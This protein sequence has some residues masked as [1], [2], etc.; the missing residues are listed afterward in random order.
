MCC[1]W[2]SLRHIDIKYILIAVQF[3]C[4]FDWDEIAIMQ[5]PKIQ[6]IFHQTQDY[7]FLVKRKWKWSVV[8]K[9][10][11]FASIFSRLFFGWKWKNPWNKCFINSGVHLYVFGCYVMKDSLR[12]KCWIYYR[13]YWKYIQGISW[14]RHFQRIAIC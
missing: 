8:M 13:V 10:K 4:H 11:S 7:G 9:K 14:R 5:L 6:S 2:H 12:N 3:L 1:F